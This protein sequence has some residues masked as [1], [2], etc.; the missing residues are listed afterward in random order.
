MANDDL[1]MRTLGWAGELIASL[2]HDEA[3]WPNLGVTGPYD[4]VSGQVQ[5]P[6]R[7]VDGACGC[8]CATA[9]CLRQANAEAL[10]PCIMVGP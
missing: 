6:P 9:C 4:R 5:R 1:W 10:Q 3:I 8:R 2:D 7:P